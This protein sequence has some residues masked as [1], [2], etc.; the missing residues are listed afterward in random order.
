[1]CVS[2]HT[3]GMGMLRVR[4]PHLI[5]TLHEQRRCEQCIL[6]AGMVTVQI[7][8]RLRLLRNILEPPGLRKAFMTLRTYRHM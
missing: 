1:M 2:V 3:T 5:Q 4:P 7:T 6:G 8:C